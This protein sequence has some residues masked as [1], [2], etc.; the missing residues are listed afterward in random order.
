[1]QV[2]HLEMEVGVCI[3]VPRQVH[4]VVVVDIEANVRHV[5]KLNPVC[6]RMSSEK[7]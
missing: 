7:S 4:N 3:G 5:H 6:P 2:R 1:M